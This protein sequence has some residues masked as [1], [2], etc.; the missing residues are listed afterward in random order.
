MIVQHEER[1]HVLLADDDPDDHF[2]FN[3]AVIQTKLLLQLTYIE[4]GQKLLKFLE[5]V[6]IPDVLFLDVNMPNTNGIEGLKLK[7][8][9]NL[10]L[11]GRKSFCSQ[12]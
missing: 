9:Q 5:T 11:P 2:L 12:A 4:D 3:E 10:L 1:I 7:R 8:A 6:D